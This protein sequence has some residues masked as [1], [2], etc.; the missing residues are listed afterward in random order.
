MGI[1][2][3]FD[4]SR[5]FLN[6]IITLTISLY[7]IIFLDFFEDLI[8]SILFILLIAFLLILL[9]FQKKYLSIFTLILWIPIFT[10]LLLP[11]ED[12]QKT[13][14]TP[15]PDDEAPIET[16]YLFSWNKIPGNDNERFIEF[17]KQNFGI[18]WV[19]TA[20]I[21]KIDDDKTIKV[22][23][24]MNSLSLRLNDEKTKVNLQIDDGRTDEFIV[25]TENGKLNIYETPM[26]GGAGEEPIET[27]MPGGAGEEPIETAIPGGEGKEPIETAMPGG[28]GEEP[29]ETPM[30]DGERPDF[31]SY[32]I[33]IL[34]ILLIIFVFILLPLLIIFKKSISI[35]DDFS[36]LEPDLLRSIFFLIYTCVGWTLFCILIRMDPEIAGIAAIITGLIVAGFDPN[37]IIRMVKSPQ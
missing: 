36:S 3:N 29:I 27:A 18:D 12:T 17:L 33:E 37:T 5:V 34:A 35:K 9:P 31:A 2:I 6:I 10:I 7:F 23:T 32:I 11:L 1:N 30:P 8:I 21:E 14:E 28:A 13:I 26:P 4:F 24:E 16:P 20:K 15:M 19:K 22:S 25:K